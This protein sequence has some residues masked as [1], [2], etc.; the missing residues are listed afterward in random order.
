MAITQDIYIEKSMVTSRKYMLNEKEKGDG[1]AK[2]KKKKKIMMRNKSKD[3]SK[4]HLCK[5]G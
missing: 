5:P 2:E 1:K 4:F 3:S